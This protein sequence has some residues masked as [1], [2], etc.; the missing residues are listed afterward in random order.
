VQLDLDARP[1]SVRTA[2]RRVVEHLR[3]HGASAEATRIVELLTSE[4]VTNAVKYGPPD[5]VIRVE[6]NAERGRLALVVSDDSPDAPV[7][8]V[9]DPGEP[10]GR[11]VELVRTLASEWGVTVHRGNGKSVWV[12]VPA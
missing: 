2:R 10:G 12:R 4:L 6:A 1:S 9:P 11:G 3:A 8:R 7:A 5:G